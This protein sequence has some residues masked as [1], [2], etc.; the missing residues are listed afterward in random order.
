M[1]FK[2]TNRILLLII[3]LMGCIHSIPPV[4]SKAELSANPEPDNLTASDSTDRLSAGWVE[5]IQDI[6]PQE[7]AGKI[8]DTA[9]QKFVDFKTMM[10]DLES[11]RVVY[12]GETHDNLTHHQNQE[13]VLKALYETNQDL[14]IGMEMFQRP[15]QTHLDNYIA[16][17]LSENDLLEK[18]EYQARWGFNWKMYRP[19]VSFAYDK[20]LKVIALN[21]PAEVNRRVA[22]VGLKGLLPEERSM[23]PE[24]INTTD[25]G[26]RDYVSKI[27][28]S[29]LG[30]G[31]TPFTEEDF[32][33]FYE[34]Q[35][36]WEDT[37]A[38]S[39]A[40]YFKTD[41]RVSS[42]MLIIV[43]SGHV[44]YRFGIPQRAARRTGLSYKTIVLME[45]GTAQANELLKDSKNKAFNN[46]GDYLWFT[47][48][49]KFKD[50]IIGFRAGLPQPGQNGILIESIDP[51]VPAAKTDLK[52]GD[53]LIAIDEQTVKK[54]D[55]LRNVLTNKKTGDIVELIVLRDNKKH[56]IKVELTSR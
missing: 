40:R 45:A 14:A 36:V 47:E 49:N 46:P 16:R 24:E 25:Q 7:L 1:L 38:D 23:L 2:K 9:Q 31:M 42:R 56:K 34:G 29:H 35:C 4:V 41:E 30:T 44:I 32:S 33:N 19:L 28:K 8:F 39:I 3:L 6:P 11:A 52:K 26:H 48:I 53:L 13:K 50:A 10:K 15:Y 21:A 20:N 27:F 5:K 37:M 54:L 17:K 12:V 43:G 22:R 51:S 55:D 18:T